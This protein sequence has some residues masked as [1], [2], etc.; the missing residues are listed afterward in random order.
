MIDAGERTELEAMRDWVAA[1]PRGP[2]EAVEARGALALRSRTLPARELNRILGLYEVG[3]VDELRPIYG[4]SGFWVSLDP[5]AG[6]DGE[7][8][9]R[10]FVPDY[11]WQKFARA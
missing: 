2:V 1:S 3:A 6:L 7:L 11:A 5:A 4:G 9:A 8:Q 10:G